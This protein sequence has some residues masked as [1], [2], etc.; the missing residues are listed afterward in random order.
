[1]LTGQVISEIEKRDN[2]IMQ[3][4]RLPN[5]I[6]GRVNLKKLGP[7]QL[8]IQ[9]NE[10][11]M[12]LTEKDV[13]NYF[14]MS[15]NNVEKIEFVTTRCANDVLIV[16]EAV[17]KQRLQAL[18]RLNKKFFKGGKV[19][20]RKVVQGGCRFQFQAKNWF[21]GYIITLG[22]NIGDGT[23]NFSAYRLDRAKE[24]EFKEGDETDLIKGWN[25][26][27]S[28][29]P[30]TKFRRSNVS[31]YKFNKKN[32]KKT[33]Y[34]YVINLPSNSP[35]ATPTVV[36]DKL[37]V[38]GGFSSS[39]FHA[40][41]E[42]TGIPVWS[43]N[44]G[45]PGPSV[46]GYY[47]DD[48]FFNTESCTLFVISAKTGK[49][50]WSLWLGDPL[51]GTPTVANGI[52]FTSYP[53]SHYERKSTSKDLKKGVP[54]HVMAGINAKSGK[55]IWQRWIDSEVI[56]SPV[57]HGDS[58]FATTFSGMVYE[59]NQKDGRIKRVQRIRATSAPI[60]KDGMFYFS[61]RS[62]KKDDPTFLE[63]IVC[64]DDDWDREFQTDGVSADY[65]NRK[66]IIKSLYAKK[67]L[68][69]DAANGF[70]S[71]APSLAHAE[72]AFIHVGQKSVSSMQNYQGSRVLLLNKKYIAVIGNK[73]K[74][75][76]NDSDEIWAVPLPGKN[77]NYGSSFAS[78]P[79][80][81]G[82]F[83]FIA[84]MNGNVVQIDPENGKIAKTYTVKDPVRY[85]PV[86]HRGRIFVPTQNG[87]LHCI[88]TKNSKLTGWNTWGGSEDRN[89]L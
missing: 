27:G 59:F 36:K 5:N 33:G 64:Y 80:F 49:Q 65:L 12:D 78:A 14:L 89:G 37:Y 50:R 86:I 83:V 88:D 67:A 85:Q 84:T 46:A 4:L 16:N 38:G 58:L 62:D 63:S 11:K 42:K 74:A 79:A 68:S 6:T 73:V 87:K 48:L 53:S 55:I 39:S 20:W 44:V 51:M 66:A 69:L 23:N 17:D 7:N 41:K 60:V 24:N 81:A 18:Y 25:S 57:A 10:F 28:P 29:T 19:K 22:S 13:K 9:I 45:D 3:I 32:V 2:L 15:R 21:R 77:K 47:N 61:K 8:Y 54:T 43:V 1:M 40:F 30:P 26:K 72:A 31:P 82:G 34:G 35:I 76:D 52:C 70:F 71:G 56:S 75:Y